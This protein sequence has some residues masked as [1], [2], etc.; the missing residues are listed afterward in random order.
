VRDG[1]KILASTF[2]LACVEWNLSFV[3]LSR[4]MLKEIH[5][6]SDAAE[7]MAREEMNQRLAHK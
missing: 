4:E 5:V 1:D 2:V 3:Q 6:L 7:P